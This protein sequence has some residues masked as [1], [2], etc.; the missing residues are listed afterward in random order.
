MPRFGSALVIPEQASPSNPPAGHDALFAKS[1][2]VLWVRNASG[3]ERLVE[4]GVL[5][6]FSKAGNL[7]VSTGTFRIY[8]DT[9]ATLNI[10]AVRAS[11]GTAPTGASVIVDVMVDGTTIFS[12]GSGRPAIAAG[13]NTSGRVTAMTTTTIADGS[14]FTVDID[15]VGSGTPGADLVVQI[16]C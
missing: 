6:P 2:G 10:R 7:A 12:G 13:T 15:Q 3:V 8:N 4:P 9:G 14:Y 1:G 5:F 11:V 16:L